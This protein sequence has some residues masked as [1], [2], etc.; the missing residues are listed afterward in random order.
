MSM[1]MRCKILQYFAIHGSCTIAEVAK[2][3]PEYSQ[4]QISKAVRNMIDQDRMFKTWAVPGPNNP[5]KDV[6]T[7]AA[8]DEWEPP[9]DSRPPD[10]KAYGKQLRVSASNNST[11]IP[12]ARWREQKIKLL[13]ELLPQLSGN[14]R[15]LMY[16]I[17]ADYG[18]REN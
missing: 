3:L 13:K 15:D 5:S 7:Y 4:P 17:L 16:G 18:Y 8:R 14:K 1:R 6:Y 12:V 11:V 10:K 2:A 9:K